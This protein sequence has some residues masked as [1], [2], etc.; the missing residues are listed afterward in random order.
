MKVKV[1]IWLF[2]LFCILSSLIHIY[3]VDFA[4]Y[5]LFTFSTWGLSI[6]IY[7]NARLLMRPYSVAGT[8]WKWAAHP[9]VY[10]E[11]FCPHLFS[12]MIYIVSEVPPEDLS[13][14]M[15]V[16]YI[17]V[18]YLILKN[19]FKNIVHNC[20]QHIEMIIMSLYILNMIVRNINYPGF[21][22]FYIS[23]GML[24]F[25]YL[26]LTI[27][28]IGKNYHR[29]DL[30]VMLLF[31][32]SAN[33]SY[34]T[35]IF[36]FS[37][38][39]LLTYLFLELPISKLLHDNFS[40]KRKSIFKTVSVVSI[41]LLFLFNPIIHVLSGH[42][43]DIA[44]LL[45]DAIKNIISV[46]VMGEK[47]IIYSEQYFGMLD[48]ISSFI[49][50]IT[51]M[52][53]VIMFIIIVVLKIFKPEIIYRP[54]YGVSLVI[55]LTF[56]SPIPIAI[57]SIFGQ[58]VLHTYMLTIS[59]LMISFYATCMSFILKLKSKRSLPNAIKA[60]AII[61]SILMSISLLTSLINSYIINVNRT[62]PRGFHKDAQNLANFIAT[63]IQTQNDVF[64]FSNNAF[65]A[66]LYFRTVFTNTTTSFNYFPFEID[67]NNYIHFYRG[68]LC[69]YAL[70][71]PRG[72]ECTAFC[73]HEVIDKSL[74]LMYN[75]G[76]FILINLRR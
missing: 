76:R 6:E 35:S 40:S 3:V 10:S 68:A 59:G 27:V 69:F 72:I 34:Y 50:R 12:A 64:V 45:L 52:A 29:S 38:L 33:Y 43:K 47:S 13:W 14:V 37:L 55:C 25:W 71:Y 42:N 9:N 65:I 70:Q 19:L 39:S 51:T 46:S 60:I 22:F 18:F 61:L 66:Q 67:P 44:G 41:A 75:D 30:F 7:K 56:I 21:S 31:I 16:A 57:Y 74:G 1:N 63:Y 53:F 49:I 62:L 17:L 15:I 11:L 24:M 4:I 73:S 48:Q 28:I 8:E 32:I 26:F 2:L 58:R 23:Y 54:L 20:P 36:M 5:D